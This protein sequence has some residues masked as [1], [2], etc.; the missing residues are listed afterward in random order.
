MFAV[1]MT[2]VTLVA[3][4]SAVASQATP[5]TLLNRDSVFSFQDYPDE[6]LRNNQ[7]GIVSVLLR[8]AADGRVGSC[9]VTESSG[10]ARLDAQ[11]CAVLRSRARFEP[12]RSADGTKIAGEYQLAT[13][14]GIDNNQP[15]SRF[16]VPLQVGR[17]P[18]DYRTPVE[19]KM[20][21]DAS[22]HSTSCDVVTTSGSVAA[23]KAACAYLSQQFTIAAFKAAKDDIPPAAVRYLTAN[24]VT[25]LAGVPK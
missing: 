25:Q 4:S 22:G 12:A 15:R 3:Q 17:I 7:F 14:W 10:H 11:T 18:P 16:T 19:L 6:S 8:I 1:A 13:P 21:F 23:D 5:P 2:V 20:I 9:S 24:L